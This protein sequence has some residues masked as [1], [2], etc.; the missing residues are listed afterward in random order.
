MLYRDQSSGWLP[1]WSRLEYVVYGETL[2]E[3]N[4]FSL[5]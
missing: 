3:L 4:L 1:G 2:G 5:I